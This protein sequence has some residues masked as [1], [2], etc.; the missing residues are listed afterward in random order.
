MYTAT[1]SLSSIQ[2]AKRFV[3]IANKYNFPVNIASERYIVNGKSIMGL[4][5][6]NLSKPVR[7]EVEGECPPEFIEDIK[8]FLIEG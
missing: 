1:L 8:S 5:S 3:N 7:V 2:S 4:F 6:L